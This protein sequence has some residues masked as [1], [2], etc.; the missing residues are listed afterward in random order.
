MKVY[1]NHQYC[2]FEENKENGV[3]L[4]L[5]QR[6]VGERYGELSFPCWV[7]TFRHYFSGMMYNK[8]QY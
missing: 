5:N 8:L 6:T 3:M 7:F 2:S 1:M 4:C